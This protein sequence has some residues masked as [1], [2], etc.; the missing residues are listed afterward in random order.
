MK[1]LTSK[2]SVV[3]PSQMNK[4][5]LYM[6]YKSRLKTNSDKALKQM[7]VM[8]KKQKPFG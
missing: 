5:E 1:I 6:F 3:I 2:K 7:G 8:P 4:Q